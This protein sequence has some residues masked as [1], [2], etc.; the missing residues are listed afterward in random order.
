MAGEK[1]EESKDFQW[2]VPKFYFSV[3]LGS[4]GSVIPF[5]EVS[6]MD[7]ESQVIEYR[8]GSDK[9]F[10]VSKMPGLVKYSNVTLKKGMFKGDNKFWEWYGKIKM[11]T[12]ERATITITLMD[13]AGGA[14]FTWVLDRAWPC[15]ITVTDL[16]SDGNEVAIETIELVHEGITQNGKGSLKP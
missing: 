15:K 16:K 11:N 5:Q 8:S 9:A 4:G 2:P 6:G 10:S 13:E 1:Q 3:D 12:I 14:L 7:V